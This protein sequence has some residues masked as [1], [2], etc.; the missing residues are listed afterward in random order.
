MKRDSKI[1]VLIPAYNEESTIYDIVKLSRKYA[2]VL[3]VDDGSTDRTAE[4]A[5]EAGATVLVNSHNKG[6]THAMIRGLKYLSNFDGIIFL[7]ADFQYHPSEIPKF[8]EK[9]KTADFVLGMRDM[10]SI[11]FFRHKVANIVMTKIFNVLCRSNYHDLTCGLRAIRTDLWKRMTFKYSGYL[12]EAEM[13]KE[14]IRKHARIA[15]VP[16]SVQYKQKSSILRGVM[17]VSSIML[18]SLWWRISKK[19]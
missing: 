7:D 9:L 5:K 19:R 1:A 17:I 8:I 14:A 6:K 11:P 4:K 18:H 10:S 12:I 15:E 3:V 16:V 2:S 13:L